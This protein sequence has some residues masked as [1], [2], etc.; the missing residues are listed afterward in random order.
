MAINDDTDYPRLTPPDDRYPSSDNLFRSANDLT[1]DQFDLLAAAWSENALPDESLAEMEALF[2]SDP[3]KKAYAEKF[4]QLH[5]RPLDDEWKGKNAL[6]RTTPT[7]KIIRRAYLVTLAAAAVAFVLL[8]LKPFAEKQPAIQAPVSSPEVAL[9]SEPI[10]TAPLA[11]KEEM[12]EPVAAVTKTSVTSEKKELPAT[13]RE[14][15]IKI[16]PVI[17][18]ASTETPVITAGIN[19]RKLLA[20]KLNEIPTSLYIPE[21][22]ENWIMKGIAGLSHAL[23]KEKTPVDG[24]LI[25]KSCINGINSV[26]GSEMELEKVISKNGETV[27][28]TFN[29]SLLSFSAPVRKSSQ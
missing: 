29:S 7:A 8:T 20:V 17:V 1:D 26:F 24:Y 10:E 4:G 18:R 21:R 14:Q 27:G 9:V 19:A 13:E 3:S 22:E 15:V 25:A 5:L 6:L 28:V 23:R 11:L 16:T 12:P 2:A